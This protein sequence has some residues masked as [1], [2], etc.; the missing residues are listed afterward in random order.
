MQD[1]NR[2]LRPLMLLVLT[3]LVSGCAGKQ[4]NWLPEQAAP[5]AIPELPSEARQPPA[6]QWCSPNCSSG[7]TRERESWQERMML[8]E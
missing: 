4:E 2:R 5:P 6:P 3:L 7:L 8:L 1:N